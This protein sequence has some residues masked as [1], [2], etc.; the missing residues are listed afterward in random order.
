MKKLNCKEC[1]KRTFG[2][3]ST[4]QLYVVHKVINRYKQDK[5]SQNYN[6]YYNPVL[7]SRNNQKL[8]NKLNGYGQ[9]EN[10]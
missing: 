9:E 8:K 10:K 1:E 5:K 3:H 7:V 6:L 4:C 2:C